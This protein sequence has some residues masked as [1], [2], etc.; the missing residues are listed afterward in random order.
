MFF[1]IIIIVRQMRVANSAERAIY[2]AGW[3]TR[4]L[5]DSAGFPSKQSLFCLS[6]FML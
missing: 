4:Y 3:G 5:V 6:F 2:N 1:I